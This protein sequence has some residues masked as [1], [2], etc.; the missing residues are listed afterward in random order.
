M[1]SGRAT[2]HAR[3]LRLRYPAWVEALDWERAYATDQERMRLAIQVSAWNVDRGTG[4]P[5]GS[6]IFEADSGVL[7]SVGMNLVVQNHNS[8]LHGE[9]VAF[10]MAQAELGTHSLAGDGGVTYELFTSCEPCAMCLG[11][12]LWSGVRRLVSAGTGDDARAIGFDEGPV[13]P[14]S[15]DYLTARGVRV[16]RELLRAD[17]KLV[18]ERYRDLGRPIYNG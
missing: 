18:L 9:M 3:E 14:A 5:F 10:Q 1:Q 6:A 13:F 4:G 2:R 15:Y 11:A 16:D 7:L 8:T 12:T 17:A